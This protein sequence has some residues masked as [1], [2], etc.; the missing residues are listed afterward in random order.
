MASNSF[1]HRLIG[2]IKLPDSVALAR[3]RKLESSVLDKV[4][5]KTGVHLKPCGLLLVP[6]NPVVGASPGGIGND[7]VA[8]IKCPTSEKEN[9]RCIL[10][11]GEMAAKFKAQ[12]QMQMHVSGKHKALFCVADSNFEENGDAEIIWLDYDKEYYETLLKRL[13]FSGRDLFLN[14]YYV[15]LQTDESLCMGRQN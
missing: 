14:T 6:G 12:I 7:Y 5:E 11:S 9:R 10:G 4:C 1:L 8:E 13:P 2:T 3:G 15:Q